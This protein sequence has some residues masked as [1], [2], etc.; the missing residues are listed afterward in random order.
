MIVKTE[1]ICGGSARIAGTRIAIWEIVWWHK[2][3]WSEERISKKLC[4]ELEQVRAALKYYEKH[5]E[6]IEKEI[7]QA[8]MLREELIKFLLFL[9]PF[10]SLP[11]TLPLLT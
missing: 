3:G 9:L 2:L 4:L 8:E 11:S 5:R 10:L 1:G 6:E 7:E